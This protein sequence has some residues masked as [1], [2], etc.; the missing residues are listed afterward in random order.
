LKAGAPLLDRKGRPDESIPVAGA[1]ESRAGGFRED[2]F[3]LL[4]GF[5]IQVPSLPD[6]IA[7]IGAVAAHFIRHYCEQPNLCS[8]KLTRG[9]V[10]TLERYDWPGT[11]RELQPAIERSLIRSRNGRLKL[12]LGEARQRLPQKPA[13]S[14]VEDDA[15]PVL[16]ITEIQE[17]E[18]ANI[19]RALARCHGQVYGKNG[20]AALLGM[21]STTLWSRLRSLRIST[22]R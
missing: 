8:R 12:D 13:A 2:L 19:E 17:M 1:S 9:D 6:R 15:A 22:E 5:P 7:D 14:R 11:T 16:T 10:E 18:R 3:Y 21:K 4:G 20:A